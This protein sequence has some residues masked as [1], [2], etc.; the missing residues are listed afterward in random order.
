M[1]IVRKKLFCLSAS[2]VRDKILSS[3]NSSNS[4]LDW[5]GNLK[6][7]MEL[8]SLLEIKISKQMHSLR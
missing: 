3:R 4:S 5:L 8:Q 2:N 1:M 7:D 6:T